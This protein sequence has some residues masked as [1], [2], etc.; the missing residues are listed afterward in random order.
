MFITFDHL[1][2]AKTENI[3][4]GFRFNE[5]L[6]KGLRSKFSYEV[7]VFLSHKNSDKKYIENAISILSAVGID[8]YIDP[9]E[10]SVVDG[11]TATRIKSKIEACN[12]FILLATPDAINSKW[13]NWELGIGDVNKY[14]KD[15]ALMPVSNSTSSWEGAEYLQIYPYI[16][17]DYDFLYTDYFVE[18]QSKR[19][20]LAQWLAN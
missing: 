1:D 6:S 20:P 11:N 12:K 13:C 10:A 3:G 7:S 4:K 15:I 17:T 9:Q 19:V 18:F 14:P 16:T 8:V 2:R 5:V